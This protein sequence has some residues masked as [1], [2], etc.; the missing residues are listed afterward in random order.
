[1]GTKTQEMRRG[2]N[3]VENRMRSISNVIDKAWLDLSEMSY[4][5]Q[6]KICVI[7]D[8]LKSL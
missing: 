1:M 2:L 4:K 8:S 3:C 6:F 5:L 7:Q